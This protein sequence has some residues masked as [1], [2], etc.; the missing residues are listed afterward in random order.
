MN[1]AIPGNEAA[2]SS[3]AGKTLFYSWRVAV[4]A[5]AIHAVLA[6]S[7]FAQPAPP[8]LGPMTYRSDKIRLEVFTLSA[9]IKTKV[10][11]IVATANATIHKQ[12]TT[13]TV[14]AMPL[15]VYSPM[16]VAT[17]HT[18]RPNEYYV[19]L[20]I[21]I[22]IK[23][24]L[25][26]TTDR[27]IYISLNLNLSCEGW[28]T[29]KGKMQI[30]AQTDPPVI[31]GGNIVEDVIRVRDLINN[32]IR[33][34][35]ALPGAIQASPAVTECIT[36]GPS[37]SKFVGDP[38]A[39]IAYDQ[40]GRLQISTA[41]ARALPTIE[42]TLQRLK[43]LQA[44]GRGAVLYQSTENILLETYANFEMRQSGLLTMREGDE[45]SL[46]LPPLNVRAGDSLVILANVKQQPTST[47]EDSAFAVW[48]R[49][50]NYSPG[51]HTLQIT[52][53]YVEPPG[54]GHTKPLQIRVPAYELTYNV[55]YSDRS[56]VVR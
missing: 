8:A 29:G 13:V 11:E 10:A 23:V 56:F 50:A 43:R 44:R 2:R 1:N 27:M 32:L 45:V 7:S 47:P 34:Q 22:A 52:K 38:A 6:V 20:P 14:E 21:T 55:K 31:E 18:N 46:K 16:R 28:E 17:L 9:I 49:A 35:I 24:R 33:N 26:L 4:L 40:P 15:K 30:V 12:T 25:P 51:V 42:L 3:V 41:A 36:I 19:R 5:I 53:V 54:P 39:F 48:A 37:P